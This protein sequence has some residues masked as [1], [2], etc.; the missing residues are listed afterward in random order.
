MQ[1]LYS[2]GSNGYMRYKVKYG[3]RR[4]AKRLLQTYFLFASG[5]YRAAFQYLN[6]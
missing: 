3:E 5:R 4:E 1:Y 2:A 6:F